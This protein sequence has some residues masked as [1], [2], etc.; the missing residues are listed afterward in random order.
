M[1]RSGKPLLH[2]S[3]R[4][5]RL[6]KQGVFR[7]LRCAGKAACPARAS[8]L[9]KGE[10]E[11]FPRIRYNHIFACNVPIANN[12]PTKSTTS[13]LKA[14][15]GPD[16]FFKNPASQRLR[17]G[18]RL[19]EDPVDAR[20]SRPWPGSSLNP[21]STQHLHSTREENSLPSRKASFFD[22][23]CGGSCIACPTGHA[24]TCNRLLISYSCL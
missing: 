5:A 24:P 8:W 13:L 1:A 10:A 14:S 2:P 9:A 6:A 7:S 19:E 12:I 21:N 15:E 22:E 23:S 3:C 11:D 17:S 16:P 4:N 20:C 18:A